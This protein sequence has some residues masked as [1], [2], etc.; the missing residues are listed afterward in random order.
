MAEKYQKFDLIMELENPDYRLWK[1][2]PRQ[3]LCRLE[4]YKEKRALFFRAENLLPLSTAEGKYGREYHL[5]L[6]GSH[7]GQVVHQDFGPVRVTQNGEGSLFQKFTG[8]PLDCYTHVLLTIVDEKG[9]AEILCRQETP[10]SGTIWAL[11]REEHR[12]KPFSDACD[13][14]GAAWYR[15]EQWSDLPASVEPCRQWI[16]SYRHYI[17]GKKEQNLYIGIPGRFLQKEQPCRQWQTF[18]LWQP[19]RGG[20]AFFDQPENMTRQQQ[21]EVFG[22]WVAQLD[23]EKNQLIPL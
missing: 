13:E 12:V 20:E 6:M 5:L 8:A 10:F 3:L 17:I 2:G 1:K 21:E 9:Q 23:R 15:V 4:T 22:Y 7:D 14:T 19:I 11:C 16:E 18:L